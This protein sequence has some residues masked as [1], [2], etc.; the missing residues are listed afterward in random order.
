[1][2]EAKRNLL[3][4][5]V[6]INIMMRTFIDAGTNLSFISVSL[7]DKLEKELLE[8]RGIGNYKVTDAFLK[9]YY[10]QKSFIR[11]LKSGLFRKNPTKSNPRQK[12]GGDVTRNRHNPLTLSIRILLINLIIMLILIIQI[13]QLI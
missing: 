1:M 13:N 3:N 2:D 10:S 11:A 5:P 6:L 12:S 9:A 8:V 7:S 4:A